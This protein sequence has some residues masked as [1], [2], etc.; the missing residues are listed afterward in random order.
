MGQ[1]TQQKQNIY[2]S[3]VD[4]E[5][6]PRQSISW[7]LKQTSIN[8]KASILCRLQSL[9]KLLHLNKFEG[10]ELYSVLSE[11]QSCCS[12]IEIDY[13]KISRNPKYLD[14]KQYIFTQAGS[15]DSQSL[16]IVWSEW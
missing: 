3:H 5:Q 4:M 11:Q 6:S 12:E 7:D 15:T 1:F 14:I 13:N 10:L 9:T 8:V 2:P 16:K